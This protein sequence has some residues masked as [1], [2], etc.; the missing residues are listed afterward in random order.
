MQG[1][2]NRPHVLM[3]AI[4]VSSFAFWVS[5]ANAQVFL[6]ENFD[7]YSD[8]AAFQAAWPVS[9]TASLVLTRTNSA[10]PWQSVEGL[11]TATRNARTIG[12]V[13][14]LNGSTDTVIFRFNFYDS[15]GSASAYR[16][17]AELDDT[18]SPSSSGQLFAIGL[19][20]NISSTYYMARI[21]GGDGGNGAGAFFS[22]DAAGAPTRSTGWHSLEAD[23]GDTTVQY[24]VDGILSKTVSISAVTDRSLDTVRVGSNLSAGQVAYYDDIYVARVAVPEP[25]V[26]ALGLVGGLGSLMAR[27]RHR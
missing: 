19:N 24:Y 15:V 4:V 22:L 1:E 6:H 7:G 3:K 2:S 9:G 12:E 18:G 16:Q 11:T 8:Q 5:W 27:R 17:Y 21:L 20:N 10:S 13:G 25:S 14:F 23:I 26:L